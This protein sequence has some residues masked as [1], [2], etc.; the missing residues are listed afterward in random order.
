MS[1]SAAPSST[2]VFAVRIRRGVQA[3]EPCKRSNALAMK[4]IN[5]RNVSRINNTRT[6]YQKYNLVYVKR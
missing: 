5:R 1:S 6:C 4:K 2:D 3:A